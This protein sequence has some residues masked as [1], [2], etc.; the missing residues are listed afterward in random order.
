MTLA[1][2]SFTFSYLSIAGLF[3]LKYREQKVGRV[4]VPSLRDYADTLAMDFKRWLERR[5]RD[6]ELL[7]PFTALLARK[8][9]HEMA[10]SFAALAR[11]SESQAHRLADFV[12]HKHRFERRAPRSEFLMRVSQRD[13]DVNV[14][15][16]VVPAPGLVVQPEPLAESEVRSVAP[17]PGIVEETVLEPVHEFTAP[18]VPAPVVMYEHKSTSVKDTQVKKSR[19]PN[20]RRKGKKLE[21]KEQNGHNI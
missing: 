21:E 13:A 3:F 14:S 7:P 19:K 16:P 5:R 4:Y 20:K 8:M 10:L 2:A 17:I 12:S 15:D 9:V 18:I 6:V 11:Y 1:I